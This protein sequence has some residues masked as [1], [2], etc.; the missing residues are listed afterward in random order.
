MTPSCFLN[1]KIV[2]LSEGKVSVY[3]VG[4]LRGFGIY[5]GLATHNRKPFMFADHMERMRRSAQRMELEVPYTDAQ[6]EQAILELLAKNV[7]EGKE[8]LIRIIE[9]GGHAIGG[10]AYDP[11]T[12]T[13]YVLVEEFIPVEDGLVQEGG[14]IATIEH[15]RQFSDMKTTNYIQAV[16]LQRR[17]R[18]EHLTEVLYV[19]GGRVLECTGSNIFVVKNGSI[20]TPGRDILFGITRKV[21]IE[22]AKKEFPLEERDVTVDELFAADEVF[23]TGSFKEIVPIVSI[24]GRAIGGGKPGPVTKRLIELFR[25]F[26]D[27]N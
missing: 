2:P 22:L 7:P 5:E 24:D 14:A 23:I 21:A 13:F 27:K 3:D 26:A 19:N 17:K 18:E 9:T 4:I 6:I 10:I 15:A 25:E 20:V 11:K 12:P 1:G 16:L 8:G